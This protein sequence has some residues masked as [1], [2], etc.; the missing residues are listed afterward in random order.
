MDDFNKRF[1]EAYQRP[2]LRVVLAVTA[3]WTLG[4]TLLLYAF[5][6]EFVQW[7]SKS[8]WYVLLIMSLPATSGV[9]GLWRR[10]LKRT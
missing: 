9:W 3:I 7:P 2:S 8:D 1:M 6:D 10:Y 5:S 4:L